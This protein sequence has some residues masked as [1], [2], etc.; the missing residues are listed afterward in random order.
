M[1]LL[2]LVSQLL[3]WAVK[4]ITDAFFFLVG[5]LDGSAL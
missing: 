4:L 1:L 5:W 2:G 3:A